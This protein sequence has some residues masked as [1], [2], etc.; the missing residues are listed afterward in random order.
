VDIFERANR[1]REEAIYLLGELRLRELVR[2]YGE[3]AIQGS[4][5][6]DVMAYPD[7]DLYVPPL[8]LPKV[9]EIAGALAAHPLVWQVVFEKSDDPGLPGGY[10]LKPRLHYG[11]WG[12]DWKIDI[13][14]VDEKIIQE[15]MSV[16]QG[17]K[18]KLTPE[19]R[20]RIL[21]Y[22]HSVL[23]REGRTPMY[24]GVW[25]YK[26]I[27][28]EGMSDFIQISNYLKENGINL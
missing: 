17:W 21:C 26:A 6:L 28:D 7:L 27:L 18:H 23:T 8:T 4:C 24:S 1:L 16:L 22:K 14:S 2:P 19:L 9:F 15:K 10:Y 3:I 25:I 20:E 12:R 5:Y 13:W 11:A